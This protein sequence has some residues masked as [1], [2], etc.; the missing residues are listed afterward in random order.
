M[1]NP[2]GNFPLNDDWWYAHLYKQLFEQK[3]PNTLVWAST[4]LWGQ[5]FLTKLYSFAFGC[6]YTALRFFTLILSASSI[7]LFYNLCIKYFNLKWSLAF[8]MNLLLIFNPLFLCL[9]NSYMTDVPFLFFILGGIY[10]Y[11]LFQEKKQWFHFILSL[12]FFV[13]A[14]LTRQVTLAFL[15]GLLIAELISLRKI[16]IATSILFVL[17]LAALFIFEIWLQQKTNN[18]IYT[19]VFFRSLPIQNKISFTDT[20]VNFG[21]RWLHFV[22]VSGFILFPILIPYLLRYLKLIQWRVFNKKTLLSLFFFIPVLI[23][24]FKFPIGN[25]IYNCGLGPDTLYD[26]Y[27]LRI[28]T[29]ATDSF[30]IFLFIKAVAALGSFAFILTSVHFLSSLSTQFKHYSIQQ[31]QA[32][33]LIF[34]SLLFYYAFLSLSSAIFDRYILVF[35]LFSGVLLKHEL[36]QVLKQKLF[37]GV[38]FFLLVLFSVLGTKD[39]LNANRHKWLSISLIKEKYNVTDRQINAGYEHE[40]RCFADS[41]FWYEKWLNLPPNEYILSRGL[42]KNYNKVGYSIYQR[43]LP[44][45]KDTL[46]YLKYQ[47]N[48]SK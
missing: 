29:S 17:P 33:V 36:A 10:F 44:F 9:S 22:S 35:T 30:V 5:L 47:G 12:V 31:K 18:N 4:S 21:K 24:L 23:S 28:N 45:R 8:L 40:G 37:T 34:T 13:F 48:S 26:V 39:Y 15:I 43:Y 27:I 20:L 42:V 1:I 14:I 19:Y 41:S 38:L 3:T 16:T 46:F 32:T 25:Y 7:L 2:I 11:F 6:S